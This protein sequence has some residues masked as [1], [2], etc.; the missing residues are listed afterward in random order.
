VLRSFGTSPNFLM[1]FCIPEIAGGGMSA[2][3]E[4][5]GSHV[6]RLARQGF[7]AHDD[8]DRVVAFDWFASHNAIVG[9]EPEWV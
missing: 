9:S 6:L 7:R 2:S 3:A 1:T 4:C 5:H 8:G